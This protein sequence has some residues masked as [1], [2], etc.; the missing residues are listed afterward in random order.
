MTPNQGSLDGFVAPEFNAEIKDRKDSENSF[1]DHLYRIFAMGLF[2][3]L[4]NMDWKI[5]EVG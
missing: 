1:A 5:C 4:E 3:S 2:F